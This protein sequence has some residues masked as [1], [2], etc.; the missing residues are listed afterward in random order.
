LQ[1]LA[2]DGGDGASALKLT[3][4]YSMKGEVLSDFEE[5]ATDRDKNIEKHKKDQRGCCA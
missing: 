1:L 2:V 4:G 5:G 3:L